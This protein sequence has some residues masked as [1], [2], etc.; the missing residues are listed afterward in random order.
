MSSLLRFKLH[1]ASAPARP[2][3]CIASGCRSPVAQM[4]A[5]KKGLC[6]FFRHIVSSGLMRGAAF[7]D[8]GDTAG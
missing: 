6:A 3:F 5:L 2:L 1:G 8:C 7:F 4:Y